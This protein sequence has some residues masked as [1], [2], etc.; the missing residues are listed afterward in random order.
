M[1][2]KHARRWSLFL[3]LVGIAVCRVYGQANLTFSMPDSVLLFSN[4]A[5]EVRLV[6]A[7]NLRALK[8]PA[9]PGPLSY[10]ALAP[11]GS[12]VALGLLSSGTRTPRRFAL[13]VL[14]A[15][16]QEWKTYGDFDAVG[17]PA[18]SPDGTRVAFS[19]QQG[20]KSRAF[21]ILDIASGAT[22]TVVQLATVVERASLGWSPD[23]KR[24]AVEMR[25]ADEP[26]VIA[27]FDPSTPEVQIIGKGVDP[28]WSP[29]GEWIA[30]SGETRQKYILIRPDGSGAKVVRDLTRRLGGYR[31]IFYGPVWSP[32]GSRILLNEMKGEGPNI[33][34]VLVDLASK[35][36]TRKSRNGLAVFGWA[37][38]KR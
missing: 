34:V 3:A 16:Q 4:V 9:P 20:P 5:S 35:K 28:A 6:T 17:I 14:S 31:M 32:D 29:T 23:G 38:E 36:A 37:K 22:T 18:F 8:L 10:P 19:A 25:R 12:R 7:T 11:D 13:G 2:R 30:Y 1:W 26:P 33:D 21:V 15:E 27:V 24:L